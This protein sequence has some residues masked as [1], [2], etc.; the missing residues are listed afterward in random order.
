MAHITAEMPDPIAE[1]E[2][3]MMLDF[4]PGDMLTRYK[5]AMVYYRLKKDSLAEKELKTVLNSK[6]NHF[7]AL[8]GMGMLLVRQQKFQEAVNTLKKAAAHKDKESGTFFYLGKA[9]QGL[10]MIDAAKTSYQ[11]GMRLLKS[12]PKK[13]RAVSLEEFQKAL[14]ALTKP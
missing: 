3:Q 14:A 1:I 5:L 13:K 8:E 9:Q 11:Q 10:G 6:P 4:E 2:Y 7:L 12:E